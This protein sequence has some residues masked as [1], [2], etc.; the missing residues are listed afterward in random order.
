MISPSKLS[1]P[2]LRRHDLVHVSPRAWRTL[3]QTRDDLAQDPLVCSWVDRGWPLIARRPEPGEMGGEPLGLPL[4]PALGK[5]RIAVLM[6]PDDIVSTAPAPE[7]R[8]AIGIAPASWKPSLAQIVDFAAGHGIVA[9]IYGSLAWRTLTGLDYLTE[10]SD[11]D[12]L[13]P[14]T[15]VSDLVRLTASLMAIEA[16]APM[17]LD[18]ELVRGDGAAVNWR[19]LHAGEGEVLV[20]RRSEAILVRTGEFLDPGAPR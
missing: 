9:R 10:T 13:L 7:L 18:G 20:K 2:G 16:A 6:R 5:R 1:S 4:P 17:R 14:F 3:V 11:L 19:E 8:A 12:L 15:R